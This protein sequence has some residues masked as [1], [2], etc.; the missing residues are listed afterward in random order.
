VGGACQQAAAALAADFA[1]AGSTNMPKSTECGSSID[2]IDHQCE[3]DLL[4]LAELSFQ[5]S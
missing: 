1:T 2:D 5:A 4:L 3:L